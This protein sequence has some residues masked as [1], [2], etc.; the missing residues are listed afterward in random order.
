VS[1]SYQLETEALYSFVKLQLSVV[2]IPQA[3]W[4]PFPSWA[5]CPD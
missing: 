2:F 1:V 5:G 3:A 4:V